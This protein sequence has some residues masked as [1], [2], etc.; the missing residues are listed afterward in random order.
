MNKEEDPLVVAFTVATAGVHPNKELSLGS[1]AVIGTDPKNGAVVVAV[2][3]VV[4]VL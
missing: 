1:V 3:V 4:R 2:A